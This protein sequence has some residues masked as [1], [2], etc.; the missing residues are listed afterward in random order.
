MILAVGL[1]LVMEQVWPSAALLGFARPPLVACVIAYYAM[2]HSAP[3]MLCAA[4]IGGVL[5]DGATGLPPGVTALA[6]AAVGIVLRHYRDTVFSGKLVTSVIFGGALGLSV[7]ALILALVLFLG[8][9]PVDL[10]L[11]LYFFRFASLAVYGAVFFPVVY[12]LLER[13]EALA[14]ANGAE[15]ARD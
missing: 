8:R 5:S 14:G 4:L 6:L 3:L 9:T 7:P 12:F 11:H 10:R 13:M 1:A 15:A 2:K